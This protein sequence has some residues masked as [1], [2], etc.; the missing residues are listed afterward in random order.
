MVTELKEKGSTQ[1]EA[2]GQ[3]IKAGIDMFHEGRIGF[4]DLK[5]MLQILGYRCNGELAA[6][7]EQ[8]KATIRDDCGMDTLIDDA[9]KSGMSR[10]QALRGLV[11]SFCEA[12]RDDTIKEAEQ[13]DMALWA[14]GYRLKET[15]LEA[16]DKET[17]EVEYEE[18]D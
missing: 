13:L 14:L 12:Y 16:K 9:L 18:D 3:V 7:M 4:L 5:Y 17:V 6:E 15:V 2:E 11:K 8:I 10:E 1:D